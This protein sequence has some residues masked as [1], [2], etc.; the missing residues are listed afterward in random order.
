MSVNTEKLYPSPEIR[1]T[2]CDK[3]VEDFDNDDK[4]LVFLFFYSFS[5]FYE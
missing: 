3:N 4:I 5:F 1:V 2:T